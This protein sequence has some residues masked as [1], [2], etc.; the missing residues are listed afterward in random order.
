MKIDENSKPKSDLYCI[1]CGEDIDKG[2]SLEC[3]VIKGIPE[4]V[5]G[6]KPIPGDPEGNL[7][8]GRYAILYIITPNAP[9]GHKI[10]G[11]LSEKIR[12]RLVYEEI[13][14]NVRRLQLSI[15]AKKKRLHPKSQYR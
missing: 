13:A 9:E 1:Y 7:R 10:G 14:F 3:P 12:R 11:H 5:L 4:M 15:L 6:M 8:L 2:H